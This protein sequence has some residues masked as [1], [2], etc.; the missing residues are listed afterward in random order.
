MI[1]NIKILAFPDRVE[2]GSY[3]LEVPRS[4]EE[5]I[6]ICCAEMELAVDK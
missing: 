6:L 3:L 2:F 5:G 1:R 4:K